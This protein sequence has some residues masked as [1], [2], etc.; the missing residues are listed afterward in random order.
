MDNTINKNNKPF[1]ILSCNG[2]GIK[3]LITVSFL[4][5]MSKYMKTIIP[6]YQLYNFFDMY[7]GTSIG[8]IIIALILVNKYDE[9]Q[10]LEHFNKKE[11]KQI[12]CKSVWDKLLGI[13]QN[14]PEYDGK[15]KKLLIEKYVNNH[16]F[17]N[18]EKRVIIPTYNITKRK[19]VIFDSKNCND[20]VLTKEIVDASS[21]APAYFP[22]VK[23]HNCDENNCN[24]W[25]IDGGIV[26]NNPT[27]S[28]IAKAKKMLKGKNRKI[29]VINIFTGYKNK[30]IDGEKAQYY[31]GP[32]WLMNNILDISMD[33]SIEIEQAKDLLDK[34]CYIEINGPLTDC[35]DDID[36]ISEENMN[37]L[38]KTG[39]EWWLNQSWKIKDIMSLK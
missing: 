33:E 39:E 29:I 23:I 35:S 31:G 1:Y 6:E 28:A 5:H 2:G 19:P 26:T 13:F 34:N 9:D 36:N 25:F 8:S 22:C 27:I 24:D 16:K 14:K 18:F 11:C 21:A 15:N 32:D 20:T 10:L 4:Y 3:G 7:A 17:I 37:N 30:I 38:I 12:I